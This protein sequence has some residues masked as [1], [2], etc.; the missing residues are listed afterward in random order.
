MAMIA[1]S[2]SARSVSLGSTYISTDDDSRE[3][4]NIISAEQLQAMPFWPPA[5][6]EPGR[7]RWMFAVWDTFEDVEGSILSN[8]V[9]G[10]VMLLIVASAIVAV[11]ETLP[12][13]HKSHENTWENFEHFFVANFTLEFLCRVTTCPS[14]RMF[15][16]TGMNYVDVIAITPYWIDIV[17]LIVT[18]DSNGVDISFLR[19]LR[20]GRAFRLV[21]LGKYSHG[22][23]LV[24]NALAASLDALNLF[25]LVLILVVVVFSS[26]IY[27]TERGTWN[28]YQELYYRKDPITHEW[29]VHPSLF[30]SIPASFWWSI[31]TLTTVGYGDMYPFTTEGKIMGSLTIL[32][33]LVMLALPL[34]ILGT[35]FVEERLRIVESREENE[36][37]EDLTPMNIISQLETVMEEV[38]EMEGNVRDLAISADKARSAI[39][40]IQSH[41]ERTEPVVLLKDATDAEIQEVA[42]G[43]ATKARIPSEELDKFEQACLELLA[44]SLRLKDSWDTSGNGLENIPEYVRD[45][46]L[47]HLSEG[48]KRPYVVQGLD[49]LYFGNVDLQIQNQ[50]HEANPLIHNHQPPEPE[51]N[52]PRPPEPPPEIEM[53]QIPTGHQH[54]LPADRPNS[55]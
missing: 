22:V 24:V 11:I 17:L 49:K 14:Q 12:D 1:A 16:T 29:E 8:Y 45:M 26:A 7:E 5:R 52:H 51:P 48:F 39:E 50:E 38:G 28:S 41:V 47:V 32:V 19:I 6:G 44:C 18:G 55:L 9:N 15:W 35:N 37:E 2:A 40:V 10:Y 46:V 53:A 20:L 33:G 13:I 30:Q 42:L 3:A 21:K 25:L 54:S 36:E 27:Y 43:L 23:A 31:T 34:S 4:Y